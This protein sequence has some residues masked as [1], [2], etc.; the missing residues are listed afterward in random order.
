MGHRGR[1]CSPASAPRRPDLSGAQRTSSGDIS[2]AMEPFKRSSLSALCARSNCRAVIEHPEAAREVA[3]G[4]APF[5]TLMPVLRAPQSHQ[6]AGRGRALH[7]ALLG[8][9]T[10]PTA[11]RGLEGAQQ[12]SNKIQHPR[13]LILEVGRPA[14][15]VCARFRGA[16]RGEPSL[17]SF[18]K[19]LG[20]RLWP[21]GL[22][23]PARWGRRTRVVGWRPAPGCL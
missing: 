23:P 2:V 13:K 11:A 8:A 22:P 15:P 18:S 19:T 17:T 10:T 12:Q 1:P 21:T 5:R 14:A 3:R 6:R 9:M 4:M 20:P 7:A 16:T